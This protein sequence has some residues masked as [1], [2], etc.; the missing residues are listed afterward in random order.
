MNGKQAK[1]IRRLAQG[2]TTKAPEMEEMKVG[3]NQSETT[4][5]VTTADNKRQVR[6]VTMRH[7]EG[8][9]KRLLHDLKRDE[10]K[11]LRGLGVI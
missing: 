2:L 5:R 9:F 1:S 3:F 10:V 8:T 4:A 6:T 7:A 11:T